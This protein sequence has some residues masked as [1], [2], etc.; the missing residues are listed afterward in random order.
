[1]FK[2]YKIA[3]TGSA[4]SGKTSVCNRLKELGLKVISADSLARDAVAPD[5]AV[6]EKIINYFGTK[7]LK[8][9]GTLNRQTLRRIMVTDDDA[10]KTLERF[11]HPE[12]KNRMQLKMDAAERDG[13][14][15]VIVEVPLLFEF[16]MTDRFDAIVLVISDRELK[17]RRLMD[18]DNVSRDEANALL[19]VQMPDQEKIKRSEFVLNNNGSIDEMIKAVD[20]VYKKI[21]QKYI[22]KGIK[23][24]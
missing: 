8:S 17:I 14:A 21:C 11:V 7:V 15:V 1:M 22:K 12:I 9:D 20:H 5:S 24:P 10:R 2:A 6:Y 4:G 13:D 16:D 23:S 19:N 18:R 3:V